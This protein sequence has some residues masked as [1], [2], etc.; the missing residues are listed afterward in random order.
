L[1]GTKALSASVESTLKAAGF[2][3]E[4]V[5]GSNRYATATAIAGKLSVKS[6][7]YLA[8]GTSFPDPLA[9]S[10]V[11]VAQ[12]GP[13]LLTKAN[14]LP[15]ETANYLAAHKPSKIYIIGGTAVVSGSVEQAL[16][17]Y[18]PRQRVWGANRYATAVAIAKTF[19][20]GVTTFTFATGL[21][22]PDSLAAGPVSGSATINGPLLLVK[23][24]RVPGEIMDYLN[25][26]ALPSDGGLLYGGP[27]AVDEPT[28]GALESLL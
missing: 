21:D 14:E 18:A 12:G 24:D 5:Y 13:I 27:A 7:V 1:G 22:F 26:Q 23:K 9:V 8:S 20:S 2:T 15:S 6:P 4:R 3:T 16:A 10:A 17:K 19:F 11:A 28:K 25:Q